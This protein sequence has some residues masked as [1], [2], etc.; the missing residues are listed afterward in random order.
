MSRQLKYKYTDLK[1]NGRLFPSWV[2]ANFKSYKLPEIVSTPGE[3]PCAKPVVEGKFELHKYQQFL[4]KFMDYN[5]P[6]HDILIYHA[7]GSGKGAN[8]INIYNMFK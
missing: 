5:S 8:T 1:I 4:A 2:L 3:D 6:Y 7:V